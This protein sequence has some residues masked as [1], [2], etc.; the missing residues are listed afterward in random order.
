VSRFDPSFAALL[1][2]AQSEGPRRFAAWNAEAF[3]A[4]AGGPARRLWDRLG[5]GHPS[6]GQVMQGY[7]RLI[8]EGVGLGFFDRASAAAEA[9][10]SL[11]ALCFCRLIPDG[12]AQI[13]TSEQLPLMVRLWNL[14]EGLRLEAAWLDRYI[15]GATSRI[16]DLLQVEETLVEIL[17]PALAGGG[18]A[19]WSGPFSVSVLDTRAITPDFLPGRMHLAAP[20]LV[21][22]HDRRVADRQLGVLLR[23]EQESR[24]TDLVDCLGEVAITGARLPEVALLDRAVRI[25]RTQVAL[26]FVRQPRGHATAPSGFVVVSAVD[27]QRLWVVESR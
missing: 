15:A 14:G 16:T 19:E 22:V 27:S 13:P 20:S 26:P 1:E 9:S 11:L 24:L 10:T 23:P 7:L 4:I 2:R 17:E 12:L 5:P 3:A 8:I 6:R 18:S 25:A 21:C